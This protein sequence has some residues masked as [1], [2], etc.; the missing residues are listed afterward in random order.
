MS[1]RTDVENY[2]ST[3]E[4]NLI[5]NNLGALTAFVQGNQINEEIFFL[6]YS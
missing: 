5:K 2:F 4:Y 1:S 6:T 3:S